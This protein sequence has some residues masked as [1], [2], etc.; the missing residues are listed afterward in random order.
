MSENGK[1]ELVPIST[2]NKGLA[3]RS[4]DDMWRF[5]TFVH[6]SGLAPKSFTTR[7]A[8]LVAIQAG[9]ELGLTPMKSLQSI[10]VIKGRPALW[11]DAAL[12][13]VKSSGLCEYVRESV[14]GE[15]ED[16]VATCESKR[17]GDTEAVTTQFTVEDAKVANL[18]SKAGTWQ[19]YP[20]IM[21]KYRARGFN[22]RDNFPDAL[23]GFHIVEEMPQPEPAYEPTT[24]KRADRKPVES[25]EI[26][27]PADVEPVPEIQGLLDEFVKLQ[28]NQDQS[29]TQMAGLFAEFC[30]GVCGGSP[31]KYM[32]ESAFDLVTTQKIASELELLSFE[33][34]DKTEGEPKPAKKKTKKKTTK[35]VTTEE[36]EKE[37][38]DLF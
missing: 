38:E 25:H 11:G 1:N 15:G 4:L 31:E 37:A 13:L 21:L 30:A 26:D 6:A 24:P 34:V 28:E 35:K 7:E 3:L 12:A 27:P 9:A 8:I 19:E 17:K 18:W 22:L 2:S 36:A 10:A 14:T 23:S 33:A 16:M 5:A 29:P 20:K 32:N